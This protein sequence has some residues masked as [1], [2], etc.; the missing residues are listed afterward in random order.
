MNDEDHWPTQ[1]SS[2]T[3]RIHEIYTN[4]NGVES[5][6]IVKENKKVVDGK[7]YHEVEEEYQLPN[8]EK[9][10]RKT[11]KQGDKVEKKVYHLR[12]GEDAPKEIENQES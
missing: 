2:E 6:K 7:I 10:I 1:E 8:G 9:E 3:R 12:R 5:R 11:I 4:K